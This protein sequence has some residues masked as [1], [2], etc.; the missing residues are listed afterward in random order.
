MVTAWSQPLRVASKLF[1]SPERD[2]CALA[3][4]RASD[5]APPVHPKRQV[6]QRAVPAWAVDVLAGSHE[7]R[8]VKDEHV[9]TARVGSRGAT[10]PRVARPRC[11]R[12]SDGCDC[13]RQN[14]QGE[15]NP[16]A[17]LPMRSPLVA[18]RPCALEHRVIID[19]V[20]VDEQTTL[21]PQA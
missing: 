13:G 7:L 16:H 5:A 17:P 10:L 11:A 2:R 20:F 4:L 6:C 12:G 15:S 3:N 14:N 9:A 21:D 19:H 18:E 1:V 8:S